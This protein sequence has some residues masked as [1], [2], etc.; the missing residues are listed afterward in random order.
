MLRIIFILISSFSLKIN[1]CAQDF[2]SEYELIGRVNIKSGEVL[3]IPL[4]DSSYYP[5]KVKI[6]KSLI[7]NG[8]FI[9]TGKISYPYAFILQ[10][11]NDSDKLVYVSNLFFLD[12]GTQKVN[13]N[14]KSDN[15]ELNIINRTNKEKNGIYYN[16]NIPMDSEYNVFY[17]KKES[18]FHKF[19][20]KLPVE[21]S[22]SFSKKFR[23]LE[24]RRDL[25]LWQYT[26][27]HPGSFVALW[28]LIG[29]L[30]SGYEPIYDSIYFQL[31]NKLKKTTTGKRLYNLLRSS[32]IVNTGK[33]FP[34]LLLLDLNNRKKEISINQNKKFTLIDFWFS[35]CYPC[36]SQFAEFKSLFEKYN[37]KNDLDI[38]SIS[39]DDKGHIS[40]WKKII[41]QYRLPW[42]QYL[43]L[44]GQDARRLSIF[45]F[46][47]NFLL[48]KNGKIIATNIEPDELEL[49]LEKN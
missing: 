16:V 25:I 42:K 26:K 40:D 48:D 39:V 15:R 36:I 8:K 20:G 1:V 10:V 38:I 33:P 29:R 18:A 14:I 43:D 3:L 2:H 35:H 9:F 28:E 22:A 6:K 41:N 34:H 13:C 19:N 17:K 32:S 44:N 37:N 30:N 4:G 7:N 27:K 45:S 12:S 21:V 31:S 46:P 11:I 47:T 49:L 24:H 5:E 23:L